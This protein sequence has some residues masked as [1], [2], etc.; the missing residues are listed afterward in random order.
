MALLDKIKDH[1]KNE[2]SDIA[3]VVSVTRLRR[4]LEGL[5]NDEHKAATRLGYEVL[6]R[7]DA[8]K[9]GVDGQKILKIQEEMA[10]IE[11]QLSEEKKKMKNE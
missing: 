3:N 11:K 8:I 7:G 6:S 9:Y 10:I 5:K 1:L 4:K 2:S